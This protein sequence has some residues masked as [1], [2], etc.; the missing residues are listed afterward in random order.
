M[1]TAVMQGEPTLPSKQTQGLPIE[2]DEIVAKALAKQPEERYPTIQA[3]QDALL[4]LAHTPAPTPPD[5]QEDVIAMLRHSLPSGIQDTAAFLQHHPQWQKESLITGY[6]WDHLREPFH[7]SVQAETIPNKYML[8]LATML[9][10]AHTTIQQ[11]ATQE[12]DFATIAKALT[13]SST[14]PTQRDTQRIFRAISK[15]SPDVIEKSTLHYIN[16]LA[17][18]SCPQQWEELE[19]I[20]GE[21]DRRRYCEICERNVY[22]VQS[23]DDLPQDIAFPCVAFEFLEP[24]E[25]PSLFSRLFGWLRRD[26]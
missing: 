24:E 16:T 17:V 19:R 8:I 18:D 6:I 23:A 12:G 1:L 3:F 22:R 5:T 26:S 25:T 11:Y 7:A 10:E 14:Q 4:P 20:D 2:F 13:Q 9:P 15:Q 21:D